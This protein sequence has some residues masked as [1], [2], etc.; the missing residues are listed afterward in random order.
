MTILKAAGISRETIARNRR[1]P[2]EGTPLQHLLE[3]GGD[4]DEFGY[5]F[6]QRRAF[7]RLGEQESNY[8]SGEKYALLQAE[9]KYIYRT[10]ASDELYHLKSDFYEQRNLIESKVSAKVYLKSSLYDLISH[11]QSTALFDEELVDEETIKALKS[12]GYVQ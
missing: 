7:N 12:L 9:W 4:P 3:G 11:L 6:V 10:T 5:A 1:L 2:I 8:E